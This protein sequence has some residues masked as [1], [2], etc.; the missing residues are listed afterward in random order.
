V[1][2]VKV[3]FPAGTAFVWMKKGALTKDAVAAAFKGGRYSMTSFKAIT[4]RP[5][6]SYTINVSGMT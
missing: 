6:R 5:P 3:D 1:D 4:V 2:K